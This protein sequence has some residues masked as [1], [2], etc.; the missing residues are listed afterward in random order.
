MLFDH[1]SNS[2]MVTWSWYTFASSYI[3]PNTS[4][5]LIIHNLHSMLTYIQAYT[6]YLTEEL[7]APIKSK[8]KLLDFCL[9]HTSNE[10]VSRL[11]NL[12]VNLLWPCLLHGAE[13]QLPMGKQQ[14]KSVAR[15]YHCWWDTKRSSLLI[16]PSD[17]IAMTSFSLQARRQHIWR[18]ANRD[19]RGGLNG[20]EHNGGGGE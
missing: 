14:H 3:E 12:S 11:T 15:S 1:W 5:I 13:R 16:V 7:N 6:S 19:Q 4:L 2:D 10:A 17:Q 8:G 9:G 20:N 18:P